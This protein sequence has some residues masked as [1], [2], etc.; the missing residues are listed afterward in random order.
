[1]KR[2]EI[3][4]LYYEEMQH[5]DHIQFQQATWL[6]QALTPL[7]EAKVPE[8][9]SLLNKKELDLWRLKVVEQDLQLKLEEGEKLTYSHLFTQSMMD[10][11][12]KTVIMHLK[13]HLL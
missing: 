12:Y 3:H 2:S 13:N 11:F 1:M 7:K 10:T 5:L 8:E 6:K 9:F 4:A